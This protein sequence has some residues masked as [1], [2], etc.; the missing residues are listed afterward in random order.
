MEGF[1]T[2]SV[3]VGVIAVMCFTFGYIWYRVAL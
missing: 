2:L 1:V 3:I